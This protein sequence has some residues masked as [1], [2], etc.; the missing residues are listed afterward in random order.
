MDS[1]S[2]DMWQFIFWFSLT[3]IIYTYFLYPLLISL[4]V[5][6]VRRFHTHCRSLVTAAEVSESYL[7][8]VT[9]VISAYNEQE[10]LPAKIRNCLALDYPPE[11]LSFLIGSDGSEDRTASILGAITDPRFHVEICPVRRGKVQMLNHLMTRATGDLVVF[12]DANTMYESDAIGPLVQP[13]REERVGVVIGKLDLVAAADHPDACRTEG[14]Y[15]RYENFLK[16]KESLL[17]AVPTINGGIFA[18]RRELYQTLPPQA[19]TEDQVLGMKIMTRG[20]RCR[21]APSARACESVSNWAG[22]L[23]R[24]IRISAGNFQSLFLVPGILN[25]RHGWV[26]FAFVSH[27][28]IRWLVPFFLAGVLL[29]NTL[30]VGEPFYGSTLLLQGLFYAC[31][32]LGAILGPI[33]SGIKLLAIPKYFIAMNLAIL[34][35]LFRFLSGRQRVTWVRTDR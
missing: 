12:S 9:M 30:L 3:A 25:P 2:R 4:L 31:G 20:Y 13:F 7:P 22:E 8:H 29:S 18:I 23:R 19:V 6:V 26:S 16:E 10:V 33:G 27:K 17:G 15:W 35:G 11:R 5:P 24:R 1:N 32:L 21:F 14:T 34:L 28:L